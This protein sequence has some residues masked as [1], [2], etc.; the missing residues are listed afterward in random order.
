LLI[1]LFN[2]D[3]KILKECYMGILDSRK[4]KLNKKYAASEGWSP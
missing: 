2:V 1:L 4:V 3:M